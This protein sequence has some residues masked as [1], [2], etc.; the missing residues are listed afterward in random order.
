[1]FHQPPVAL[2]KRSEL[3]GLGIHGGPVHVV[4]ANGNHQVAGGKCLKV[5]EDGNFGIVVGG[6]GELVVRRQLEFLFGVWEVI[7]DLPQGCTRDGR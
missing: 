4:F 3:A 1:M 2:S 7:D 6:I 5:L